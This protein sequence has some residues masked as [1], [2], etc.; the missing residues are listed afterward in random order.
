MSIVLECF[1]F[2]LC[3]IDILTTRDLAEE[4]GCTKLALLILGIYI[5]F[6]S[7]K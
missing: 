5:F 4:D 6:V 7:G 2:L 1:F 3:G